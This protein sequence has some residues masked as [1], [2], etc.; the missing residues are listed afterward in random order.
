MK[1]SR[2]FVALGV[3]ATLVAL[4]AVADA[5]QDQ[6]NLLRETLGDEYYQ[7]C[8]LDKLSVA[9]E[10]A[11][12]GLLTSGVTISYTEDAAENYLRKNGW[13][14]I[15]IIGAVPATDVSN[16]LWLVVSDQYKLHTLDPF[17]VDYLPDPGVYWGKNTM[18]S[19][20]IIYPDGEAESFSERNTK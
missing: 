18:S 12:F 13:R 7:N 20:T 8:G 6:Q 11:L 10:S 1:K 2:M 3:I 19:W 9:E 5:E 16:D 15:R 17:S 14:R 4:F